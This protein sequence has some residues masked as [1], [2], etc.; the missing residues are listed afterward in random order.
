[1]PTMFLTGPAAA[2]G[3]AWINSIGNLGGFFGPT[4]VGWAKQL[5]GSFAGGLYALSLCA[6][7]SAVVSLFGLNIRSNV[8]T[9]EPATIL[10][11]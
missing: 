10:A 3:I 11:E 8:R 9:T 6:L 7:V 5:T 2:A 1:M 4:I